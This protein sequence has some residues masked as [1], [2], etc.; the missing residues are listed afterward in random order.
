MSDAGFWVGRGAPSVVDWCEPNYAFTPYIAEFVNTLTSVPMAMMGLYGLWLSWRHR[1]VISARF[2]ACFA[3][4]AMVGIGSM[5]FHGTLLRIPQA[6]DELPM[7]YAI[8]AA[9]WTMLHRH[10]PRGSGVG[11]AVA[12]LVYAIGFTAAYAWSTSAFLIF[13]ATFGLL[14]SYVAFASMRI[15]LTEH[16][17]EPMPRLAWA[18]FVSFGLGFF[19]F[20]VP[21]HLLLPCDSPWQGLYLH[22]WWHI[23]S[24]LGVYLW[25]CWAVVDRERLLGL[26]CRF[27]RGFVVPIL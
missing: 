14:T 1:D 11:L 21:E 12:A 17:P 10:A 18:S 6:L 22:A 3:G 23:F 4:L 26:A 2:M 13:L 7:V 27:E 8:L 9:T 16:T 20:W 15:N 25:I 24:G 19:G 5:A